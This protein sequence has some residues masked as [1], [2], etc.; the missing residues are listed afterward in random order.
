MCEKCGN[1]LTFDNYHR[2]WYCENPDCMRESVSPNIDDV[3]HAKD[4][5][6]GVSE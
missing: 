4:A 3:V 6:V 2:I 1:Y 5:K